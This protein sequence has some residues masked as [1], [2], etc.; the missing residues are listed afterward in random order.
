MWFLTILSLIFSTLMTSGLPLIL[1]EISWKDLSI[2]ISNKTTEVEILN[3]FSYIINELGIT[4]NNLHEWAI[5]RVFICLG[6]GIATFISFIIS[7]YLFYKIF[8]TETSKKYFNDKEN[9]K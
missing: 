7:F 9:N 6:L 8:K 1:W 2:I 3:K 4:E 5:Q